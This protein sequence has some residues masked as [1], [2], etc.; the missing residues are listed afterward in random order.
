ERPH[1]HRYQL[2]AGQGHGPGPTVTLEPASRHPPDVQYF[3]DRREPLSA[4]AA[5][6]AAHTALFGNRVCEWVAH[7][8]P[9]RVPHRGLGGEESIHGLV[10]AEAVE[11]VGVD[12]REGAV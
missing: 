12:H 4:H 8:R 2:V 5:H 11:V 9:G 1:V 7:H 10:R 6:R 3:T